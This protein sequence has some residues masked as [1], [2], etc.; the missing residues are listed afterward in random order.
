MES[1]KNYFLK[2]DI[3]KQI[4]L[5]VIIK[6]FL[7]ILLVMM[8]I[9]INIYLLFEKC[10]DSLTSLIFEKEDKELKGAGLIAEAENT[11]LLDYQKHLIAKSRFIFEN[12][13]DPLFND[14]YQ[15][16]KVDSQTLNNI[17]VPFENIE[18]KLN[19]IK[20]NKD[21]DKDNFIAYK[22][23]S[24][25]IA[26]INEDEELRYRLSVLLLIPSMKHLFKVRHA[27]DNLNSLYPK[28]T[29]YSKKIDTVLFYP[30]DI[31]N[32]LLGIN[33]NKSGTYYNKNFGINE[34]VKSM[35]I[36]RLA[37]LEK[38]LIS[39]RISLDIID[40]KNIY[41]NILYNPISYLTLLSV[42]PKPFFI[43]NTSS[44]G[45][46]PIVNSI[47]LK[48]RSTIKPL[49]DISKIFNKESSLDLEYLSMLDDFFVVEFSTSFL[50][51]LVF[52]LQNKH[53]GFSIIA[54]SVDNLVITLSTCL[55]M[56]RK[57]EILNNLNNSSNSL[58]F[59]IIELIKTNQDFKDYLPK[60]MHDCFIYP[61]IN[62]YIKEKF[63]IYKNY[64]MYYNFKRKFI[65][66][67]Y[68]KYKNNANNFNITHVFKNREP[69]KDY[70]YGEVDLNK[71]GFYKENYDTSNEGKFERVIYT[72][73]PDLY[74][75]NIYNPYYFM[76]HEILAIY[77]KDNEYMN[78]SFYT[79]SNI[80]YSGFL[81]I[82]VWNI[83][84]W[85][86]ETV[87]LSVITLRVSN[88]LTEPVDMLLIHVSNTGKDEGEIDIDI[89]NKKIKMDNLSYIYDVN[90]NELFQICKNMI[91]GGLESINNYG[92]NKV[93]KLTNNSVY[94]N[95]FNNLIID[96]NYL[97]KKGASSYELIFKYEGNLGSENKLINKSRNDNFLIYASLEEAN[98]N[99]FKISNRLSKS[100]L[101]S[102]HNVNTNNLIVD[103]TSKVEKSILSLDNKD[104][105][106]IVE[107]VEFKYTQDSVI[108]E[109]YNKISKFKHLEN[110]NL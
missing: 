24:L 47:S 69:I 29:L 12:Y 50:D 101:I 95:K 107:E 10:Y 31:S 20:N 72:I 39:K 68:N 98:K 14:Y 6:N 9:G 18:M 91:K 46:S 96:Y 49:I 109:I 2:L 55:K 44:L 54:G 13:K 102:N 65:L 15:N 70:I 36:F 42:N 100:I 110:I 53:K 17:F 106:S 37:V 86:L 26:H 99:R 62:N 51:K 105:F 34:F 4:I 77:A 19:D 38:Y 108:L 71:Q 84:I 92:Y 22:K 64:D 75:K 5:G 88:Y 43:S 82:I 7:I 87:Y 97:I 60:S 56:I 76:N 33:Q 48:F 103:V 59:K 1:V 90:I 28:I 79:I 93:K 21:L 35:Q 73:I 80:F 67:N 85:I 25:S 3:K 83:F 8:L 63:K 57:F 52:D 104:V 23:F 74:M 78:I 66:K 30:I 89:N 41:D 58:I 61:Y 45:S 11:L 27:S 81:M 94:D 40:D 32:D 16:I